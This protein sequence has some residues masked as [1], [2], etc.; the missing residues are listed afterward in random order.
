[1][2]KIMS[3]LLVAT[4]ML[5]AA[6]S[7][8]KTENEVKG[9]EKAVNVDK[10]LL[11]VTITL[12]ASMF[13]DQNV[14]EAVANA[15]K[16]G[17]TAIKNEDGSVTYKMSKS[18]HKEMMEE[19]KSNVIQTIEEAKSGKDYQSIKD[20]T[21][22]NNFSEFTMIVDQAAYENSLDGFAALGLGMSGMM[23][24]LFNGVKPDD[25]K[26][27]IYVKDQATQ[28]VFDKIVYPDALKSQD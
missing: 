1:M 20:I 23:V 7:A 26:V 2:K 22:K 25:Y 16:E 13:E 8:E 17:I 10:G 4:M 28:T 15:Q 18:N 27:T 11:N 6:C 24:E 14:D 12:P 21:Y 19:M 9:K 5:L 3:V